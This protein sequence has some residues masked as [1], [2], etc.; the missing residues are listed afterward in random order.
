MFSDLTRKKIFTPRNGGGGGA[1]FSTALSLL[2][3]GI[4]LATELYIL[5]QHIFMMIFD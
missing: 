4:C 1:T 3:T 5:Q 2:S